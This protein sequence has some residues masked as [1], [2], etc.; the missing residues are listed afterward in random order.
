MAIQSTEKLPEAYD[1][2]FCFRQTKERIREIV[3]FMQ[4]SKDTVTPQKFCEA[5]AKKMGCNLEDDDM[6]R[7][8]FRNQRFSAPKDKICN[9]S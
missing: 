6:C 7:T 5:A 3:H 2:R 9:A 1:C 8:E 4:C